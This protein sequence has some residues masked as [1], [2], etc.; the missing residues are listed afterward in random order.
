MA[1]T[2]AAPSDWTLSFIQK[3]RRMLIGGHWVGAQSEKTLPVINPAT[4][5]SICTVPAGQAADINAA[6][7]A[8]RAA[9]EGG[10]W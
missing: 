10:A 9:L 8:A 5:E 6:V 4:G 1:T 3:E 7:A 2:Q